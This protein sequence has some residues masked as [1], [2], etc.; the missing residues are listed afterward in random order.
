MYLLKT[1]GTK[2]IKDHIQIRDDNLSLL[3]VV[4]ASKALPELKRLTKLTDDKLL[5]KKLNELEYGKIISFEL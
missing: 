4:V 1:K 5:K 3:M 2:N